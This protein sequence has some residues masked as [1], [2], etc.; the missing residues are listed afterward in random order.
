MGPWQLYCQDTKEKTEFGGEQ[1]QDKWLDYEVLKLD[2]EKFKEL[3]VRAR[4][5]TI[6]RQDAMSDIRRDQQA[7]PIAAG[8]EDVGAAVLVP[9]PRARTTGNAIAAGQANVQLVNLST[10]RAVGPIPLT[11]VRRLVRKIGAE[12]R[13]AQHQK[14]VAVAEWVQEKTRT[15]S[16]PI[17]ANSLPVGGVEVRPTRPRVTRVHWRLPISVMVKEMAKGIGEPRT[18]CDQDNLQGNAKPF[19]THESI[20]NRWSARHRMY[21]HTEQKDLSHVK[22][23]KTT[24]SISRQAGMCLCSDANLRAFRLYFIALMRRLHLKDPKNI[25]EKAFTENGAVLELH[26]SQP[27]TGMDSRPEQVLQ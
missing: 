7:L 4:A 17:F 16:D 18:L 19:G 26:W 14:D 20:R 9:I 10:D 6:Q 2:H 8:I 1:F 25:F 3:K 23:Q 11:D 13:E 27:G 22:P 24:S 5:I 12:C 15:F 21:K